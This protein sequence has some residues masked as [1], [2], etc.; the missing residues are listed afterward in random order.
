MFGRRPTEQITPGAASD[1]FFTGHLVLV[2][3]RT[4]GEYEKARVP[5]ST[6]IPLTE[7]PARLA[8]LRSDRP[9]AFLCRSGHRSAIAARRAVKRRRDVLNVT[10]GMNAWMAAGL[11]VARC[12][13]S[14]QPPTPDDP[15]TP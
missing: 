8:E 9:V 7:L 11:P 12:P 10:G 1:R 6:H 4:H 13:V 5:G 3:V 14:E 15:S 2:D